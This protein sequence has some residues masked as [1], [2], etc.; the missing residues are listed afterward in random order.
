MTDDANLFASLAA[1]LTTMSLLLSFVAMFA[2][3]ILSVWA[4][5][6]EDREYNLDHFGGGA[7]STPAPTPSP[8]AA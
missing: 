7:P 1:L 8:A 3:L 5:I 4:G 6:K 2:L